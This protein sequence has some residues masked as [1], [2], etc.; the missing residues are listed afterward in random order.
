MPVA[1][2]RG[3]DQSPARNARGEPDDLFQDHRQLL[4]SWANSSSM[5]PRIRSVGIIGLT[6]AWVLPFDDLATLKG[7]CARV[8][9][10]SP[11]WDSLALACT[12][13]LRAAARGPTSTAAA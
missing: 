12:E 2:K 7:T 11:I 6:Q 5:W 1:Y 8:L 13:A 4:S 9:I 10:Y 3:S